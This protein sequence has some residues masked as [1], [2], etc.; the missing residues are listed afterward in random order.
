[1]IGDKESKTPFYFLA[2][3]S[4]HFFFEIQML[5]FY[6]FQW[7]L[8]SPANTL[9]NVWDP[10]GYLC[11]TAYR[12]E[13]V[14]AE[15]A[16]SHASLKST[17]QRGWTRYAK[18]G[19]LTSFYCNR[20]SK[21]NIN[22]WSTFS[23]SFHLRGNVKIKQLKDILPPGF[24]WHKVYLQYGLKVFSPVSQSNTLEFD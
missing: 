13:V 17:G 23:S 19:I 21:Y 12:N 2:L 22:I 3:N 4:R 5:G 7:D 24:L 8:N 10:G 1:M 14:H 20:Y 11:T 15:F 16:Y 9:H 6:R 18:W